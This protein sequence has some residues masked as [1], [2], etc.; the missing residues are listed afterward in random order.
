ME[1]SSKMENLISRY[2]NIEK[3]KAAKTLKKLEETFDD[4]EIKDIISQ[5]QFIDLK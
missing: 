4:E 5:K 2:K 1:H 3:F